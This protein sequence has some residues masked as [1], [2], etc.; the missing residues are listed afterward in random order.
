MTGAVLE[1]AMR[2]K[3]V[4]RVMKLQA[5]LQ[6]RQFMV[7]CCNLIPMAWTRQGARA[8][9][10]HLRVQVIGKDEARNFGVLTDDTI[11]RGR[12]RAGVLAATATPALRQPLPPPWSRTGQGS[13]AVITGCTLAH[14]PDQGWAGVCD[15]L[16]VTAGDRVS[17]RVAGEIPE[18]RIN[19][20]QDQPCSGRCGPDK[21][22]RNQGARAGTH[23]WRVPGGLS[24]SRCI[25][26]SPV[27]LPA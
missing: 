27:C 16:A 2:P 12:V 11:N 19:I 17:R 18:A 26:C 5:A 14:V 23:R 24:K 9:P 10:G 13:R 25:S 3:A 21:T 22:A 8:R 4:S 6:P 1:M 20:P 7:A 15:P